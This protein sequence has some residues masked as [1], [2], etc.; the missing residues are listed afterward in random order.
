MITSKK[1]LAH[2]YRRHST[3]MLVIW[4]LV[5]F[6]LDRFLGLLFAVFIYLVI[7]PLIIYGAEWLIEYWKN[8][9]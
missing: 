1:L 3:V 4:A 9:Q 2:I 6:Y 8:R 5:G 7:A